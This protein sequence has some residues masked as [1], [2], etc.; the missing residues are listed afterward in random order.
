VS[1]KPRSGA[2]ATP[3]ARRS[4][5]VRWAVG[6]GA[7]LVTAIGL[8]LMFLL[9]QA[10]NNRALYERYYVRLFGINVVV[11]VLLVLVIGWVAFRLLRRCGRA[12]SAAAC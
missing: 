8:V 9:A 10:T 2:A 11:A 1:T 5:A 6:V 7:A 12:S 3:T 4:R